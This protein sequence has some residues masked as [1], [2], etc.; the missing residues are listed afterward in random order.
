MA[1]DEIMIGTCW[2]SGKFAVS[3]ESNIFTWILSK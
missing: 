1:A 2:E 3:N